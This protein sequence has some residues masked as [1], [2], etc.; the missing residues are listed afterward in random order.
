MRSQLDFLSQMPMF[1]EGQVV[2]L[3][4]TLKRGS[5]YGGIFVGYTVYERR[6]KSFEIIK[7]I[8]DS[9]YKYPVYRLRDEDDYFLVS[10]PMIVGAKKHTPFNRINESLVKEAYRALPPYIRPCHGMYFKFN[11][12]YPN[13]VCPLGAV[14]ALFTGG[15][16]PKNHEV[17]NRFLMS[18]YD[19]DYILG[20]AQGFDGNYSYPD[21]D[22]GRVGWLDGR[23]TKDLL[24][25]GE[26]AEELRERRERA[27]SA[28]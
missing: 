20:F 24:N 25:T 11:G 22:K 23:R 10:E 21:T 28:V 18:F 19:R 15:E 17:V 9:W 1:M 8:S 27:L 16:I 26:F 14:F 3:R 12:E 6:G 2:T 7:V 13:R 5:N 4:D